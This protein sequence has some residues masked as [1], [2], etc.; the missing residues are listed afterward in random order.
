MPEKAGSVCMNG[1]NET[2]SLLQTKN[3][4]STGL[5]VDLVPLASKSSVIEWAQKIGP[6]SK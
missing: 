6:I 3:F 2:S 4:Q 1:L 5:L